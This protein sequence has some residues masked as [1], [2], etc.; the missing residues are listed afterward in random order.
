MLD[1]NGDGTIDRGAEL[2]G[3]D[4]V[5]ADGHTGA[6]G[7]AALAD[8][9]ANQDGV[10]NAADAAYTQVRLWQDLN[11]DGLSQAGELKTLAEQGVSAINL[12]A[13]AAGQGL[14]G[15][16]TLQ[17]AGT[18]V[19]SDGTTATAGALNLADNPFYREFGTA[20][21][22]TDA[23][24]ALPDMQGSGAVRDLQEA[25]SQDSGFAAR[26]QGLMEAGLQTRAQLMDQLDDVI[27]HWAGTSSF[28]LS[29]DAATAKG[30]TLIYLPEGMS[31][32]EGLGYI[33]NTSNLNGGMASPEQIAHLAAMQ[34]KQE[35]LEYLLSV[36]E[37]FNGMGFVTVGGQQGHHRNW[38]ANRRGQLSTA[39]SEQSRRLY[40]QPYGLCQHQ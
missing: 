22:L 19:K 33:P 30:Y 7:F 40:D 11:Q 39:E 13:T 8:L 10:F 6:N 26:V 1:R 14:A 25:A 2:F 23:A 27:D 37:R 21:P 24:A 28:T 31:W 36:L 35:R 34:V 5:L 38:S 16:N 12:A 3:V 18:Y 17:F 4:T 9:D 32:E 20:V 15:G 29:Q